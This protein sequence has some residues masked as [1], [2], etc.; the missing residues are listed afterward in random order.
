MKQERGNSFVL[1]LF[2]LLEF[3]AFLIFTR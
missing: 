3:F 1:Q 2:K